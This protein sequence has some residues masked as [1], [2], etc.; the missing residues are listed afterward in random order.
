MKILITGG[1]GFIGSNLAHHVRDE[2]PE[3]EIRVIDDLSTGDEANLEGAGVRFVPA[4]V[5][6]STALDDVMTG[7]DSVIHLAALGSVPR[8]VADP[9]ATHHANATGTLAVLESARRCGVDHL[10]AASSSSV[11]GGNTKLPKNEQD[12]TRPLSP[13]A[14]SKL[15]T[16]GYV[17]AFRTTY[18]M[19][20]LAFRFFNVF[21]PRQSAG[22][23][24]AAVIPKFV[25][26]ALSGE[27]VVVHGDGRQSRDF[28]FVRSVTQVLL[29]A[30][31]RRTSS[32]DPVNLA[33]GTNT[34][35]LQLLTAMEEALDTTIAR[36]HVESRVGD[37]R[38]S[39]A[40]GRRIRET[41]PDLEPVDFTSGLRETIR[42]YQTR[43]PRG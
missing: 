39:Q 2:H 40:D 23:V 4:S 20:T 15:A 30:A 12:W 41:F 8:S 26:A 22:H 16:E 34:S 11:Y 32:P 31:E 14:V 13:Y 6:D 37:V 10:V 27:P 5:L 35:L 25:D 3:A 43:K 7:I 18:G 28:T 21:G 9:M 42:W 19:K 36:K 17:N 33:Y 38:D 29:S 24:Y 1:A